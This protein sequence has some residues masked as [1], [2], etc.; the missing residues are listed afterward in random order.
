MP[1]AHEV[2]PRKSPNY[3]VCDGSCQDV[4]ELNYFGL[5]D[6][7]DAGCMED[8]CTDVTDPLFVV[9]S[10]FL[11]V[12]T[13]AVALCLLSLVMNI[14][15]QE[16]LPILVIACTMVVLIIG[17]I[18]TGA[19]GSPSLIRTWC[20]TSTFFLFADFLCVLLQLLHVITLYTYFSPN[21]HE[22]GESK[23]FV[24]AGLVLHALSMVADLAATLYGYD[25]LYVL[26]KP[27]RAEDDTEPLPLYPSDLPSYEEAIRTVQ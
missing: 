24:V 4:S 10:K 13:A 6:Q 20:Y 23:I 9:T 27:L 21:N 2:E 14:V 17:L 26:Q 3:C 8:G 18:T 16:I 22:Y 1:R 25:V 11:L 15:A 5:I 7:L 19:A 12:E